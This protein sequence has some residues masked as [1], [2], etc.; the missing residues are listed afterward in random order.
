MAMK[1]FC[2]FFWQALCCRVWLLS[3]LEVQY[4]VVRTRIS[5]STTSN[6]SREK[7]AQGGGAA[8]LWG[9]GFAAAQR[10]FFG[11]RFMRFLYPKP[12]LLAITNIRP[13][14]PRAARARRAF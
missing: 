12:G 13:L 14:L 10:T 7:A 4:I 9:R 11:P 1:S 3:D 6:S 5:M 8:N 2:K